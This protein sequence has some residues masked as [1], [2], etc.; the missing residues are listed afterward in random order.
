MAKRRLG[1]L[2]AL[3]AVL[4]AGCATP[5]SSSVTVSPTPLRADGRIVVVAESTALH[6]VTC[7]GD[8]GFPIGQL[9]APGGAEL[10]RGEM[11]DALRATITEFRRGQD[12]ADLGDVS[13]QLAHQDRVSALF[14][15]RRNDPAAAGTWYRITVQRRGATWTYA[16]LGGC[17]LRFLIA[18]RFRPA[19]W[20]VDP[21]RPQ[22]GRDSTR[23]D[24]LLDDPTCSRGSEA[25]QARAA[26]V[27]LADDRLGLLMGVR[28]V[29]R[30][31]DCRGV[32]PS[33]ASVFL[34]HP[35]GPRTLE[36]VSHPSVVEELLSA[37]SPT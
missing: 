17:A 18:P 19:L 12:T 31:S 9:N 16:G 5:P 8:T 30:P 24:I 34:P 22:P 35:L 28:E 36:D 23:I 32:P 6:L 27:P 2:V 21:D 37:L 7:G 14:I 10:R 15:A 4:A 26:I 11:F 29:L 3:V 13:W 1:L 20:T 33:A 25:G